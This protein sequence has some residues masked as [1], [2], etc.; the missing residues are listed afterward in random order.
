MTWHS[1]FCHRAEKIEQVTLVCYIILSS[2]CLPWQPAGF[3]TFLT[4]TYPSAGSQG[5]SNEQVLDK[6]HTF[7]SSYYIVKKV[8][9]QN[10]D[11][12]REE[13]KHRT[14]KKIPHHCTHS[15][16]PPT[17]WKYP[18][19]INEDDT[20]NLTLIYFSIFSQSSIFQPVQFQH[21]RKPLQRA[22][23]FFTS[24]CSTSTTTQLGQAAEYWTTV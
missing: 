4:S 20:C 13:E 24:Q 10:S 9:I 7:L 6:N 5:T 15:H 11:L 17:T 8:T 3:L 12:C 19:G 22:A 23:G 2:S 18:R 14:N 1:W 16:L 21:L